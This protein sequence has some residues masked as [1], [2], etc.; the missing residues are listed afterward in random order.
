MT[1]KC[2]ISLKAS[3]FIEPFLCSLNLFKSILSIFG[4]GMTSK[5]LILDHSVYGSQVGYFLD[6]ITKMLLTRAGRYSGSTWRLMTL[7]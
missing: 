1:G 5:L 2:H 3:T 4:L 6:G 7:A